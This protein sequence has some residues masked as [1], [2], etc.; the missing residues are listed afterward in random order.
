RSRSRGGTSSTRR[1]PMRISPRVGS[2][3]PAII[4]IVVVLPQ[5][6]GPSSTRNSRS[7][8]SSDRSATPMTSP[9]RFSS[10]TRV[11]EAM[12]VALHDHAAIH[13]HELA[14]DEGGAVGGQEEDRLGDLR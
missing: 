14:G 1:S 3:S 2:S 9:Q 5:P 13:P 4:R 12:S 7:A 11:T 6:E 10:P 8:M